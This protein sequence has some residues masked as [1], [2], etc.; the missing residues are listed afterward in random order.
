MVTRKIVVIDVYR[1]YT[2]EDITSWSISEVRP[3]EESFVSERNTAKS[4]KQIDT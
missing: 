2:L 4:V 3:S 1:T